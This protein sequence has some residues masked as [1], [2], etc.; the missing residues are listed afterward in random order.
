MPEIQQ[1]I[2]AIAAK[3]YPASEETMADLV[4]VYWQRGEVLLGMTRLNEA[5][6]AYD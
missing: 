3:K 4:D 5:L 1:G 6:E 2:A